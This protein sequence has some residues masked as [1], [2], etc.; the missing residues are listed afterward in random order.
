MPPEVL[1]ALRCP[2]CRAPLALAGGALRCAARHAFDLSRHGYVSFLVGRPP[3]LAGDDAA[4]VA[5]RAR[6]LGAGHFEPL[7]RALA[8]CAAGVPD[9]RGGGPAAAALRSP[10]DEARHGAADRPHLGPGVAAGLVVEVGAGTA[11][12]LAR[13]LDAEPAWAGLALDLS[14]HAAQRAARAHPRI[15]A[16]VADGRAALPIGDGCAAVVLDVFAPR[17]GPELRRILRD[18][19]ALVVATPAPEHLAELRAPLGLLQVDPHK[20]RR[21]D[22]A[23]SPWFEQASTT[24]LAWE[25][26][27]PR[28]DVVALASMGPS[29]R[30]LDPAALAARAA[31]LPDPVTVTGSV[32]VDR[33]RPRPRPAG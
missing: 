14:K 7:S 13:L 30:H 25:M 17:H 4:M 15:G 23:L 6:F 1:A 33:W 3:A 19:G 31:A 9:Q 12:H 26:A 2:L 5:A 24:A 16:V 28:G 18:D 32:R 29:A 22:Q 21:L 27:L 20:L 10:A 8:A 11:H